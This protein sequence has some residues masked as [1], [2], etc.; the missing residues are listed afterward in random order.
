MAL[1]ARLSRLQHRRR[2]PTGRSGPRPDPGHHDRADRHRR[3]R[4]GRRGVGPRHPRLVDRARPGWRSRPRPS[5]PASRSPSSTRA[6]VRTWRRR[7]RGRHDGDEPL[8]LIVRDA[9]ADGSVHWL[10]TGSTGCHRHRGRVRRP[11]RACNTRT[12]SGSTA[13]Q[14]PAPPTTS[15]TATSSRCTCC[16]RPSELPTAGGPD[17]IVATVEDARAGGGHARG[18]LRRPLI[19][20][21]GPNPEPTTSGNLDL[22]DLDI[23]DLGPGWA[24]V[25]PGDELG[26][27]GVTPFD[28]DLDPTVG[29]VADPAGQA[30][31]LRLRPGRVPEP[32]VLHPTADP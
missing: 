21:I 22:D 7:S 5:P 17:T 15:S 30:E 20:G 4:P 27:R 9:D 31:S 29:E 3:G 8:A 25:G 1:A 16:R 23:D 18:P 10:V 14:G 13:G 32:H 26:D 24:V 6:M 11:A 28:L 2:P 12:A 19:G